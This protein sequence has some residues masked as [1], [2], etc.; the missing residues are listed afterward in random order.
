[1]EAQDMFDRQKEETLKQ[2]EEAAKQRN[3]EMVYAYSR[4]M[5]DLEEEYARNML[6]R[7]V[8]KS[9]YQLVDFSVS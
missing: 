4:I 6:T 5:M 7:S 8:E 1:M 3:T 2:I 9:K